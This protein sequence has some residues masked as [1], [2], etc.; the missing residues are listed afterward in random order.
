ML[1]EYKE[2]NIVTIKANHEIGMMYSTVLVYLGRD[3]SVVSGSKTL[4]LLCSSKFT[5]IVELLE[6][7]Y[8][9]KKRLALYL[10]I[11]FERD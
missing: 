5:C 7:D 2:G 4:V 11:I 1:S 3:N 10:R 8:L 6:G 9:L